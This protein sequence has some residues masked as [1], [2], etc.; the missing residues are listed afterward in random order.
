M[1]SPQ[2][3]A[4]MS[5]T[6]VNGTRGW[7]VIPPCGKRSWVTSREYQQ[8]VEYEDEFTR[9]LRRRPNANLGV[10]T[11]W[12]SGTTVNVDTRHCRPEDLA[13]VR[14]R[15]Y[16]G[17]A[18]F[19]PRGLDPSRRRLRRPVRKQM[20]AWKRSHCRPTLNDAQLVRAFESL[21]QLRE[22]DA[23]AAA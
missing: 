17:G 5:S 9:W 3:V 18:G 19:T 23:R 12:I 2:S 6:L 15:S 7:S 10:V 16:F 13:P 22:R 11:R 21:A 20:L 8:H 4:M 1:E 14:S